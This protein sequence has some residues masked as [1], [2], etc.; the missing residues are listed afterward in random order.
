MCLWQKS[1]GTS[2]RQRILNLRHLG[3]VRCEHLVVLVTERTEIGI[4]SVFE[5]GYS[6][7]VHVESVLVD[8]KGLVDVAIIVSQGCG[9]PVANQLDHINEVHPVH[10]VGEMFWVMPVF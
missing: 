5:Y 6:L 2:D 4:D 9:K 1:L 8:L 7:V 3:K 10:S